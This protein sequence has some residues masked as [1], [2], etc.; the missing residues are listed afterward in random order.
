MLRRFLR[1]RRGAI[2]LMVSAVAIPMIGLV[3]L[4]AEAGSWY[5]IRRHAQNAADAAAYG[6]AFSIASLTKTPAQAQTDG[7]HFATK[8]GFTT[9]ATQKVAVTIAGNT[10]TAVVQQF[11]PPLLARLFISSN[12]TIQAT[13]VVQIQSPQQVCALA[14][15]G[16]TIGGSQNFTG[17]NCALGSNTDVKYASAPAFTGSG[18]AVES[19]TGCLP[20]DGKCLL[21]T[22]VA[23]NYSHP[24]TPQPVALTNLQTK[25][26]FPTEPSKPA[27]I[28]CNSATCPQLSPSATVWQGNLTVKNNG[29]QNLN[30]GASVTRCTFLFDSITVNNG[31]SL[32]GCTSQPASADAV[33]TCT[34]NGVNIVIGAGGLNINGTVRLEAANV[35]NDYPDLG[36][37]PKAQA[38]VLFYDMEG[39]PTKQANVTVNG[40]SK[41]VYGGAMFF[42]NVNLTW[43][44]N[45]AASNHCTEI[46]AYTL[47]FTG[48]NATNLDFA[49][50]PAATL[51]KSQTILL[52]N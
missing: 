7:L 18:W 1:C 9:S 40:G 13:A 24:P 44:G 51:P 42:P 31:G 50:C 5:L 23:Y 15:N 6:G 47:T 11:Q 14:L 36:P 10:V 27:T 12:V 35:N 46:V 38:G 49:G 32:S 52:V 21:P 48:N 25:V 2:S 33:F 20:N 3:G 39:T 34:I 41:S 29:I 8:N 17:G 26:T 45:S 4:G 43:N 28:T 37:D 22:G 30:C 16:M 19:A